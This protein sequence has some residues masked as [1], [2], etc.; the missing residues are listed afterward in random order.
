MS[1][2]GKT[3][4]VYIEP[5]VAG[6]LCPVNVRAFAENSQL[7]TSVGSTEIRLATVGVGSYIPVEPQIFDAR[8]RA[9]LVNVLESARKQPSVSNYMDI[10]FTD[11]KPFQSRHVVVVLI[12]TAIKT[13]LYQAYFDF[14]INGVDV[15]STVKT[16]VDAYY[17]ANSSYNTELMTLTAAQKFEADRYVS[18]IFSC[19][20]SAHQKV[21][22]T[23]KKYVAAGTYPLVV[24][25]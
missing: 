17:A 8:R 23:V 3:Y 24:Y 18:F 14:G 20:N 11:G 22:E 16:I 1:S 12:P 7:F 15:S 21:I 25:K 4:A 9:G 10:G 2:L 13:G 19:Q 5:Y 6:T